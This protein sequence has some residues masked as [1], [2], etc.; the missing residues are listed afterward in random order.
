MT[1]TGRITA[2]LLAAAGLGLGS[3]LS[4][5][6]HAGDVQGTHRAAAKRPAN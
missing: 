1:K 3:G 4:G 6:A 5:R 2:G